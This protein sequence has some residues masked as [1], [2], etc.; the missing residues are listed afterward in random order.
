MG[1]GCEFWKENLLEKPLGRIGEDV[2]LGNIRME[3][4]QYRFSV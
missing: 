4:A 2:C 1:L 3:L